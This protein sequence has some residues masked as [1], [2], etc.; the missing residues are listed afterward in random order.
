MPIWTVKHP[1][2]VFTDKTEKQDLARKITD[3]Y[4]SRGLPDYYVNVTFWKISNEDFYAAGQSASDKVLVEIMHIARHMDPEH[5]ERAMGMK[6][7]FDKLLRPYTLDR[8]LELEFNVTEA[9]AWLWRINGID[10]PEA[11]G[12]GEKEQKEINKKRLEEDRSNRT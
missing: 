9:P 7:D 5:K 11:F 10:P 2:N 1:T 12:D 4:V 3:W 6:D 8:G